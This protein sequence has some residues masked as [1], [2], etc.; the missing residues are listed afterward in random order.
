[1]TPTRL[2]AFLALAFLITQ[3]A[4]AATVNLFGNNDDLGLVSIGQTGFVNNRIISTTP[5]TTGVYEGV[6]TGY[7][8]ADSVITV[9]Y[10]FLNNFAVHGILAS[11]AWYNQTSGPLQYS[12]YSSTY[13]GS[14]S[15]V[16]NSLTNTTTD[17]LSPILATAGLTIDQKNGTT[18]IINNSDVA[19]QFS[20]FFGIWADEFSH[21]G[22]RND[23]LAS[24][25]VSA[26]PLPAAL[27]MFGTAMAGLIA[28][29]M[30]RKPRPQTK[31]AK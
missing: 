4:H 9:T 18:T 27:P 29:S 26:V 17:V 3:P 23:V 19:V 13:N 28:F 1:M 8:P 25:V 2:F 16:F 6:V 30:L 24:Y 11:E 7:L 21:L 12:A 10:T 20:S 22:R 5:P 14:S 31:S 15:T